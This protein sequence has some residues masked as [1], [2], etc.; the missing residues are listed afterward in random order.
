MTTPDNIHPG[1][2]FEDQ[3]NRRPGRRVII[4]EVNWTMRRA[5]IRNENGGPIKTTRVK[6][7]RLLQPRFYKVVVPEATPSA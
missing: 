7:D 1:A 3:H 5:V 2:I 4:L 6:I